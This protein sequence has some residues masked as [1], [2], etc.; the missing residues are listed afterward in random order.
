MFQKQIQ[1]GVY[2]KLLEERHADEVFAVVERERT[3]LR[4]WLPWVD[5]TTEA[6]H[7]A[8]FIRTSLEQ[9]A[10]NDGFSAGIWS[11]NEFIGGIGTHKIDWLYRRVEIGYWIAQG[12]QGRGI[13]TDASRAVI[14]HAFEEWKLNRVEIHCAAGNERSCAIPKRL[15]FQ[16]EG[17]LREAQLLNGEY[18][19]INVYALLARE[20]AELKR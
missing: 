18:Q 9:F 16:W 19:D 3:Y 12:F 10:S 13:V 14:D 7:T 17:L 2:L 6:E 8:N 4:E 11:G 1:D 5:M 20:W 15:G